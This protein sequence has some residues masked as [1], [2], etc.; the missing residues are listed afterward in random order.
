MTNLNTLLST[1]LKN[2]IKT[3]S[4]WASLALLQAGG[5]RLSLNRLLQARI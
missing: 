1:Q 2:S 5:G 4:Q 3:D